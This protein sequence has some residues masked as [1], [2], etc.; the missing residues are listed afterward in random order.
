M[1]CHIH[2]GS[3]SITGSY[4][5]KKS[6]GNAIGSHTLQATPHVS[7]TSVKQSLKC[8]TCRADNCNVR[9]PRWRF[10]VNEASNYD[11]LMCAFKNLQM[12][13]ARPTQ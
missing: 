10:F 8:S 9:T 5:G 7:V 1:L 2:V 11:H 12:T 3:K 4:K 6:V 13:F